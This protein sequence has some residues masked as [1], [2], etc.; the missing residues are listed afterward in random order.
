MQQKFLD[1]VMDEEH[2]G[3]IRKAMRTA[4]YSDTT[5]SSVVINA[6]HDELVEAAKKVMATQAVRATY[7]TLDI[8]DNPATM[9]AATKLKAA[10]VILDRAGVKSKDDSNDINLKVPTGGLVILPAKEV[11]KGAEIISQE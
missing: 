8:L 2:K 1:V 9:G 6:L 10:Q 3:N 11:D 7:E 5:P 4:G